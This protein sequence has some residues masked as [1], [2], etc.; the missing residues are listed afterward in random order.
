MM[1]W[2][3]TELNLLKH[4]ALL[5]LLIRT[6]GT[7]ADYKPNTHTHMWYLNAITIDAQKKHSNDHKLMNPLDP[8]DS[9]RKAC[10]LQQAIG[11]WCML[12]MGQVDMWLAKTCRYTSQLSRLLGI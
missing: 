10:Q 3:R 7:Y 9:R 6:L 2:A 5:N 4:H 8:L 11:I 1:N 12:P